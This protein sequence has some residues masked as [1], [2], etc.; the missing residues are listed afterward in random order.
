MIIV[1]AH[2]PRVHES[3]NVH[4]EG[5]VDGVHDGQFGQGLHHQ[6][7][8]QTHDDETEKHGSRATGLEGGTRADKQTCTDCASAVI[9]VLVSSSHGSS[10]VESSRVESI[11][12]L[13][14]PGPHSHGNHLHVS[15]LETAVQRILIGVDDLLILCIKTEL[16]AADMVGEGGWTRRVA[17][18]LLLL[19]NL[20]GLALEAHVGVAARRV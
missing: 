16:A 3:D 5:A 7:D 12:V 4:C 14:V 10:R 17:A 18:E 11:R 13:R 19:A 6:V 20:E 15:A 2:S 1:D 9:V 8:H